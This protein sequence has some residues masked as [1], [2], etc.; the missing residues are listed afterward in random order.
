MKR[1]I[2]DFF[3]KKDNG[4]KHQPSTDDGYVLI[5]FSLH[6]VPMISKSKHCNTGYPSGKKWPE[7]YSVLP[8]AWFQCGVVSCHRSLHWPIE[9]KIYRSVQNMQIYNVLPGQYKS[10][11]FHRHQ[12]KFDSWTT[13]AGLVYFDLSVFFAGLTMPA[14]DRKFKQNMPGTWTSDHWKWQNHV[15]KHWSFIWF[16]NKMVSS[17]G[18]GC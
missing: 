8:M 6:M 2:A 3:S 13:W 11:I 15:N 17:I 12:G 5:H 9:M 14:R 7:G 16:T 10:Y 18:Y 1:T 4:V